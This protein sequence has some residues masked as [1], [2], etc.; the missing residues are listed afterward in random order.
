MRKTEHRRDI[1]HHLLQ[2]VL[3]LGAILA[4]ILV[5]WPAGAQSDDEA[6]PNLELPTLG[7]KQLWADTYF[8]AGWRIQE[9]VVTGHSRLLDPEDVR[10]AWGTYDQ[11]FRAFG[12]IRAE[13]VI[14]PGPRHLVLLLHGL[15]RSKDSFGDLPQR[16]SEA[17]YAASGLNYASMR[18]GVQAS[19]DR[20]N[21]LLDRLEDTDRVSFVT[22]SMGSV[23]LRAAL[24]D[25]ASWRDR[26]ALHRIVLTAPPS[27]G[28][29]V[30]NLLAD[31]PPYQW[32]TGESGQDLTGEAMADLPGLDAPFGIIAGGRG[33]GKGFNPLIDGDDD[34][35]LA[36]SETE[37]EGALDFLLVDSLHSFVH[38]DP[39]T[40][41]AVLNFL[42][43]GC[44]SCP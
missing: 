36:V 21:L 39:Q 33:D 26:V 15:F 42:A 28:S 3:G 18:E 20:L 2:T 16:L 17:G 5:I 14:E 7:G 11:C 27:Q 1:R 24:A 31:F 38:T 4:V 29:A 41:D 43:N 10:H 35:T 44:F 22:H 32:L 13:Q 8:Y 40:I 34:G 6:L 37:L 19:A 23:V 12:K 30:A 25:Q 9:N